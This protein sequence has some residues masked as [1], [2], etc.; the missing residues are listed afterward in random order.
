MFRGQF[1]LKAVGVVT[2]ASILSLAIVGCGPRPQ[3]ANEEW[4]EGKPKVVVSFA[5]LYCFAANV[6]GEDATVK[7]VMTSTGPHDFS[8]TEK[9]V[10]RA[11]QADLFFVVGL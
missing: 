7:N 1:W 5:P 10:R 2:L 6:A 3:N 11:S 9:E 4:P 8:P